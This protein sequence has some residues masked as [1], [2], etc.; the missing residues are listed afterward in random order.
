MKK[1]LSEL[2]AA[3]LQTLIANGTLPADAS[4]ETPTRSMNGA[5]RNR[6]RSSTTA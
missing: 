5:P 1:E 6:M 4:A 3:A 2:I